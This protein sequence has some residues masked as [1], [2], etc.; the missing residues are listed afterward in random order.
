MSFKTDATN[1]I[2][3]YD[4][5]A[6]WAWGYMVGKGKGCWG[7]GVECLSRLRRFLRS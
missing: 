3:T 1:A 7:V 4:G 6:L 5:L 2:S